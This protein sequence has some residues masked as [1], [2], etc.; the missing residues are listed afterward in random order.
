MSHGTPCRCTETDK[1]KNWV[2]WQRNCNYSAFNGYK[3]QYSDYS[4]VY[5]E[6]CQMTWRT[7]AAY[8]SQLPDAN[9]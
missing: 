3:R 2:V 5:C 1:K 6:K 4:R 8:V 9:D 7:K